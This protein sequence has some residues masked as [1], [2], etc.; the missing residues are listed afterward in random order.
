MALSFAIHNI[1][2]Q[3]PTSYKIR[4]LSSQTDIDLETIQK[5]FEE[6]KQARDVANEFIEVKFYLFLKDYQSK[7][8]ES[9]VSDSFSVEN[10]NQHPLLRKYFDFEDEC[11]RHSLVLEKKFWF[12]LMRWWQKFNGIYQPLIEEYCMTFS[13]ETKKISTKRRI[14]SGFVKQFE[15][16]GLS[17]S[18][19]EPDDIYHEVLLMYSTAEYKLSCYESNILSVIEVDQFDSSNFKFYQRLL[20]K[21]AEIAY[22]NR[23]NNIKPYQ[24]SHGLDVNFDDIRKGSIESFYSYMLE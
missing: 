24:G 15:T 13:L 9:E 17:F 2:P 16:K 8:V 5:D 20:K 19:N 22:D 10:I 11:I 14:F 4:T 23:R 21:F 7:L 18:S 6:M 1:D 12:G 3:L